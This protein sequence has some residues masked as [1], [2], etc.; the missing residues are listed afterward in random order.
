MITPLAAVG[1]R[2]VVNRV[3][4]K[5]LS[6]VMVLGLLKNVEILGIF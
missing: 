2:K 1:V 3:I 5:L 6:I 4:G